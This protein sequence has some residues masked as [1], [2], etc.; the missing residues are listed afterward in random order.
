MHKS[1]EAWQQDDATFRLDEEF[2]DKAL[3]KE[4]TDPLIKLRKNIGIKLLWM[5]GSILLFLTL[6]VTTDQIYNR[7]L[8]SPL[9]LAYVVGLALIYGQYR[10]LN[11]VDKSQS[12][13]Y[14]LE[15]YYHRIRRIQQY[16]LRVALFLYPVSITAGFVYGFTIEK[17]AEE[18]LS[19]SKV[20]MTLI[21]AN[22]VLIPACY[23]LARWMDQKAYGQYLDRLKEDIEQLEAA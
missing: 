4:S 14:I 18:I 12:M 9:L 8:I 16:E 21:A 17:S 15:S 5:V 13:K 3:K 22:I 6:I 20:W 11:F 10:I 1:W 19:N 2:L 7:F 23:L